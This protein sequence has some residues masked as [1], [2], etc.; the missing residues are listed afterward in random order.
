MYIDPN[1]AATEASQFTPWAAWRS[2]NTGYQGVSFI[3]D[4]DAVDLNFSN[5]AVYTEGDSPFAVPEPSA[6]GLIGLAG[7][8]LLLRRR[9]S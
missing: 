4:T 9:R 3:S 7:L 2:G 5:I 6:L 1:L 8:T